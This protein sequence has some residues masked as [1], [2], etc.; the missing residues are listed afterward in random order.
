MGNPGNYS[1][2]TDGSQVIYDKT[3]PELTYVN[4]SSNNADTSW[5][6]VNDSISLTFISNEKIS[7]P[8]VFILGQVASVV[9]F[10]NNKF[11]A[12]YVPTDS[13]YRRIS[14]F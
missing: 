5:A 14:H 7:L 10:Q 13:D 6:K 4:I 2:T 11:K 3:L 9:D 12:I 1:L 8:N